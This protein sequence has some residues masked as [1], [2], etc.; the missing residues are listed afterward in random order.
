VNIKY[1]P[2][3][4]RKRKRKAAT[5]IQMMRIA[6][7]ISVRTAILIGKEQLKERRAPSEVKI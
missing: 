5:I 2:L 3:E 6:M 1:K 7:T 4:R